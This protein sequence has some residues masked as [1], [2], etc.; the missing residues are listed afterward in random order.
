MSKKYN[1]DLSYEDLEELDEDLN[2]EDFEE[3]D[4]DEEGA[5]AEDVEFKIFPMCKD[6]YYKLPK[7]LD[8]KKI[9]QEKSI[10]FY[11][12]LKTTAAYTPTSGKKI[13]FNN[14]T[15]NFII[16]GRENIKP[17]QTN[18]NL[19]NQ[20]N[21]LQKNYKIFEN[22]ILSKRSQEQKEG[23]KPKRDPKNKNNR[24]L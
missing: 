24:K 7:E 6:V 1:N 9:R 21:L 3:I 20:M 8:P 2:L 22:K 11:N 18:K 12:P 10:I 17:L 23:Y 19:S 5:I 16:V 13:N 14:V 4:D 15:S